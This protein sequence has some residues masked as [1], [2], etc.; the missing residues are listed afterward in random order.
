[1][2]NIHELHTSPSDRTHTP[3]Y[4][5][6]M[7]K[8][9]KSPAESRC[10]WCRRIIPVH[11]GPGRPKEFCCQACRQWDWVARQRARELQIREDE[12]VVTRQ[13]LDDLYDD[14]YVLAC[15]VADTE[16]ELNAAKPTVAGLKEALSWLMEAARPLRDRTVSPSPRR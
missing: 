8:L 14:L 4:N 15:A 5:I 16:D 7:T 13:E 12:L 10:R 2:L 11:T 3:H 1:M 6:V 9:S